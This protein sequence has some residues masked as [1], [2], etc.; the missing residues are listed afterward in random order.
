[1]G[2]VRRGVLTVLA[3]GALAVGGLGV[4][5]ASAATITPEQAAPAPQVTWWHGD[6]CDDWGH[7]FAP[8]CRGDRWNWDN[9]HHRW[10]HWR[11]DGRGHRW[12][13]R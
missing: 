6:F 8:Q 1:M 11:W 3:A 7:R 12:D 5:T 4:G 9:R 10:D 2:I 13:H